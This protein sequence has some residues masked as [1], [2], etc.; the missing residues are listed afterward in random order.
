MTEGVVEDLVLDLVRR[1]GWGADR[2]GRGFCSIRAA[3]AADLE[4]ALDL[5]E[6]VA[7]VAHDLAGLGDVAE[8]VGE[9]QQ[10]QLPSGTLWQ[11][12][13]LGLLLVVGWFSDSNL[14]RKDR[15]P[16]LQPFEGAEG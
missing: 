9:L 14:P 10:R 6:R 15:V 7:V 4:R 2:A 8:L 11:G 16:A 1:R 3:D 5:V 12:G 13:H